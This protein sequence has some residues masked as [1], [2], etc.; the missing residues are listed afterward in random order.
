MG[1]CPGLKPIWGPGCIPVI[2]GTKVLLPM[3]GVNTVE[4]GVKDVELGVKTELEGLNS[5]TLGFIAGASLFVGL[6]S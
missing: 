6:K 2:E 4:L 1:I 5:T 3:D